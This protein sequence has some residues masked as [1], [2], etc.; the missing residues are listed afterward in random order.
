MSVISQTGPP[1]PE[2]A[3][4]LGSRRVL[5]TSV[6]PP[7]GQVGPPFAL[8]SLVFTQRW[9]EKKPLGLSVCCSAPEHNCCQSLGHYLLSALFLMVNL[10]VFKQ[11]FKGDGDSCLH[12][13]NISLSG[14]SGFKW[15][16]SL[17]S[18]FCS[19]LT[20]SKHVQSRH[21][22]PTASLLPTV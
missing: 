16:S 18:W 22:L 9:E 11:V 19:I 10:S 12:K 3:C 15:V 7:S 20:V 5:V 8:L 2:D 4:I 1:R 17:V 6:Y 14:K 21:I 13:M